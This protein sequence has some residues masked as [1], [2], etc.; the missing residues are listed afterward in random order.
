MKKPFLMKIKTNTK[1][2]KAM[3]IAQHYGTHLQAVT[4]VQ[5]ME[6]PFLPFVFT[7]LRDLIQELFPGHTT[8]IPMFLFTI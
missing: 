3:I 7:L 2:L 6:L 1:P 5:E 8:A 4:S